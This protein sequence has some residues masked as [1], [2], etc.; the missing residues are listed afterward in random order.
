VVLISIALKLPVATLLEITLELL[1]L[2]FTLK[3]VLVLGLT[4]QLANTRI[5]INKTNI[6]FKFFITK[7]TS[8]KLYIILTV[9]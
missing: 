4:L 5:E 9:I 3:L 1:T 2:P 6:D 8:L 7:I